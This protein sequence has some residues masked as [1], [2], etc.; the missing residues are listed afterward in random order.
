[1]I[2]FIVNKKIQV[3]TNKNKSYTTSMNK[4]ILPLHQANL[5]R[6]LDKRVP[7]TAG[8]VTLNEAD[9]AT[10]YK[11]MRKWMIPLI[12]RKECNNTYSLVV[13]EGAMEPGAHNNFYVLAVDIKEKDVV[14]VI[15]QGFNL[16]N[17]PWYSIDNL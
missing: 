14:H 13:D 15:D 17:I 9:R 4:N 6:W 7:L 3:L 1:M 2:L 8:D 5:R 16:G 12:I 11:M 10:L